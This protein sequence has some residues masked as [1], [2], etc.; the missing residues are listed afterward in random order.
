MP[1]WLIR[2]HT[3][4]MLT[5]RGKKEWKEMDEVGGEKVKWVP[6]KDEG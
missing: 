2:T 1:G 5:A 4:E 6:G 3:G